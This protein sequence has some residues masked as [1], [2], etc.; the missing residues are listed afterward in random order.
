MKLSHLVLFSMVMSCVLLGCNRPARTASAGFRLTLQEVAT[1]TNIR[2]ALLTIH[3]AHAG[4]LSVD[5]EG[6]HHAVT[7]A[8]PNAEESHEG[9]IALIASRV[10]P[11]GDGDILIQTLIRPQLP[12][13][14]FAGGPSTD[15][16][17]RPTRLADYFTITGKNG[18]YPLNTP[19]EIARLRGKPVTL[20]VGEPTR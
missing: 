1:D 9:S 3:T 8:N 18:D 11:P 19:I 6:S 2:V 20:T 17:P 5:G 16:V 4:T 10:E 7:L 15:R 12:N 14:S 13:G